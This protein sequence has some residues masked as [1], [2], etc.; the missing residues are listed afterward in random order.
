MQTKVWR[1]V[2][3]VSAVVGLLCYALSSIFFQLSLWRMEYVEN[4]PLWRFQFHNLLGDFICR[5][6]ATLEIFPVQAHTVFLVLSIH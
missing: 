6:S 5:A 2:G 3:F 4:I 1:F